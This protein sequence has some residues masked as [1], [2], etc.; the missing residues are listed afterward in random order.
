MD[1]VL[2]PQE[3]VVRNV[4]PQHHC[5]TNLIFK[6]KSC[7]FILENMSCLCLLKINSQT[8]FNEFIDQVETKDIINVMVFALLILISLDFY[9]FISSFSPSC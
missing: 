1:N 3:T 6:L 5:L 8:H 2:S 4:F 9:N 7:W